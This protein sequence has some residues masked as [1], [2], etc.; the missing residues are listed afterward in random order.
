MAR[1]HVFTSRG[2][3]TR[4]VHQ[5]ARESAAVFTRAGIDVASLANNHSLD[6]GSAG[7]EDS[8]RHLH[9]AGVSPI[10][11]GQDHNEA[12]RPYVV[13]TP[14]GDVG[15]FAFGEQGGTAPDAGSTEPGILALTDVNLEAAQQ[16][17]EDEDI[18]WMVAAVHWGNNY[19]GVL[20]E[21]QRWAARLEAKG[22]DLIAGTGPH[23]MQRIDV[24]D[25]AP[26]L[27]SIGNL[28]FM[29]A[30]RFDEVKQPGVGLLVTTVLT[31]RGF[32]SLDATCINTDNRQADYR[33]RVC[34]P[35]EAD[36]VLPT[37]APGIHVEG[38]TAHLEW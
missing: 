13:A 6:Q 2:R 17:S 29:T 15:I 31:R 24:I 19:E 14:F 32:R 37:L 3:V 21:Q 27:Y 4:Y 9:A 34:T 38:S 28:A 33:P 12:V 11:A 22:F 1:Y 8:R 35:E 30:G 26:V 16:L 36:Q 5:A 25:R 20:P 18:E 23:V 7:L 10:G